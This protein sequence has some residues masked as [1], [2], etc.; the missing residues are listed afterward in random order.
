[1]SKIV[2]LIGDVA[3]SNQDVTISLDSFFEFGD[4]IE[5]VRK[6]LRQSPPSLDGTE[7]VIFTPGA[8][9]GMKYLSTARA[10][11]EG[12][13]LPL[14]SSERE[15]GKFWFSPSGSGWKVWNRNNLAAK[16]R[17]FGDLLGGYD[18]EE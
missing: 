16:V 5:I 7:I 12:E 8:Y 4:N 13:F 17:A 3:I 10:V 2:V 15:E 1:M 11:W 18:P 14:P 6:S 9:P